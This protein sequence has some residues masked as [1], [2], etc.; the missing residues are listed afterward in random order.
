M[1]NHTN[2]ANNLP[3]KDDIQRWVNEILNKYKQKVKFITLPICERMLCEVVEE[4]KG[5]NIALEP[6]K[7]VSVFDEGLLLPTR[8]GFIIKYGTI[9]KN[10]MRFHY[11]K[12]RETICHELAHILFYDCTSSIPQLQMIPPEHQ[13][14]KIATQLLMPSQI[15]RK[16]FEDK[17]KTNPDLIQVVQELSSSR[18]FHVAIMLMVRKLTE[19]LSLL[20]DTMVTFWKYK[21]KRSTLSNKRIH[22]RDYRHDPKLSPEL[23]RLLPKY[24]R[25]RIHTKAWNEVRK[26]ALSGNPIPKK[27]D[28][29]PLLYVGG[30]R[31]KGGKIK[32]ISFKIQCAP[33][34]SRS[35]YLQLG[36]EDHIEP[37]SPILS[38]KKFNLEILESKEWKK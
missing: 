11:V 3:S 24:W 27:G 4:L 5:V 37:V 2:H 18:N 38:V 33:L 9:D 6:D 30:T 16:E 10:R 35:N 8:G 12:I 7:K 26:V 34:Y 25:D 19:D 32:S 36:W 17:I 21:D 20:R 23:R 22:Y 15:V 28:C 31:K 1:N 13:C 14:H 29:M